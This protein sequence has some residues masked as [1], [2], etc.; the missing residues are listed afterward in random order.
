MTERRNNREPATYPVD[1]IAKLLELTPRRINQLVQEG[2][3]P[4]PASRG[5]YELVGAVQGYIRYLRQLNIGEEMDSQGG[6]EVAH[7]KRLTKARADI[8]EMEVER[9]SG[10][11]IDVSSVEHAWQMAG[12]RFRQRILSIPH[13]VAPIVAAED[14]IDTCHALLEEHCHEALREL[15]NADVESEEGSVD[16]PDAEAAEGDLAAAAIDGESMVGSVQ[17]T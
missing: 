11:L 5:R 6:S 13:K 4:R 12:A 2:V 7:R 15:A 16:E 9:L 17:A 1:T 3:I 10:S 14:D 8:A